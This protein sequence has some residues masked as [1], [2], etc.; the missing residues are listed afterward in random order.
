MMPERMREIVLGIT[1]VAI[2]AAGVVVETLGDGVTA[3]DVET[4]GGSFEERTSFCVSVPGPEGDPADATA[5]VVGAPVTDDESLIGVEPSDEPPVSVTGNIV[6]RDTDESNGVGLVGFG[7]RVEGATSTTFRGPVAGLGAAA[8]SREAGT[9]WYFPAG[10]SARDFN[11]W[12]VLY[13]PFPDEAVSRVDFLTAEGPRSKSGLTDVAVPAGKLVTVRVNDF[14]LQ[15]KGLGARVTALRGRIVAWKVMFA[16]PEGKPPGVGMTLGARSGATDWFFPV[17]A[18]APGIDERISILNPTEDEA[19][20]TVSLIGDEEAFQPSDLVEMP[21]PANSSVELPLKNFLEK[22]N[23]GGLSVSV[24]SVNE[25]PIVVERTIWYGEGE[26][27]GFTSEIGSPGA[28]ESWWVGP[29]AVQPTRDS[30][31]LLSASE[32]EVTVDVVLF[33]A[34]GQPISGGVLSDIAIAPGGRFRVGLEDL[35]GG[36][37]AV[38]LVTATGDIV[39]ERVAYSQ[40]ADDVATVMGKPLP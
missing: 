14:F 4:E 33:T 27:N 20:V 6:S 37:A 11:E 19:T 8:C 2:A 38:A 24:R 34:E 1:V 17:G 32:D 3:R 39:A 25:V 7:S 26:F 36:V 31:L 10:S 18:L 13:N 30:L 16:Q 9:D 40:S 23:V 22:Q 29:A 21:V 12:L 28:A 15:Q 35:T 5:H